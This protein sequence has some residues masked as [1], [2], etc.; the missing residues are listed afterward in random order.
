MYYSY[1]R[2]VEN[3][4]YLLSTYYRTIYL[5]GIKKTIK[6][7]LNCIAQDLNQVP[8]ECYRIDTLLS[9]LISRDRLIITKSTGPYFCTNICLG[10]DALAV[11]VSVTYSETHL[12]QNYLKQFL[13]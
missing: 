13:P 8:P 2:L 10:N 11:P 6:T 4:L 9:H 5:E 3:L 7:L 1:E 12:R